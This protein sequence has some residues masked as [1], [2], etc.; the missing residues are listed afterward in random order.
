MELGC[1]LAVDDEESMVRLEEQM[2]ES[3]G[4]EVVATHCST[5]ALAKFHS[6]PDRFDLVITDMSM[7]NMT[8]EELTRSIRSIERNVPI[9]LCTGSVELIDE[10]R[11]KSIGITAYLRKP[12]T[13]A[14]LAQTVC[15]VM[16]REIERP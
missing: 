13:F 3:L 16:G 9:I 5:D 11:A 14:K 12:F 10:K 2:L 6:E 4:Y 1:I 7:P 8:G 15:G